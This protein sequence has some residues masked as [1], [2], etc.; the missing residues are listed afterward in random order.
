M[1]N[2]QVASPLREIVNASAP[3]VSTY[4][5]LELFV[6]ALAGMVRAHEKLVGDTEGEYP[7]ADS[8]CIECTLGTV[9][10]RY[11]TGLCAYHSA[12]KL[13]GK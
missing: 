5:R 6:S 7:P 3:S 4:D 11:N 1:R 8:G 10:D 12:K 9:P 13:L 2:E